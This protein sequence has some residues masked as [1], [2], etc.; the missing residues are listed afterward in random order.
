M[1]A[2]NH[3][4]LSIRK[5]GQNNT[6]F[7]PEHSMMHTW[8]SFQG[9]FGIEELRLARRILFARN[10]GLSD[11]NADAYPLVN[12]TSIL[13]SMLSGLRGMVSGIL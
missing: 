10:G 13:E 9:L 7:V 12:R 3:T 2:L 6:D 11:H 1:E 5:C 8:S 4:S